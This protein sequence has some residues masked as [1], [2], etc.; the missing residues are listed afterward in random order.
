[1]V[2]VVLIFTEEYAT[3][4]FHR[5]FGSFKSHLSLKFLNL[6]LTIVIKDSLKFLFAKHLV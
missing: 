4:F 3:V 6:D 2:Q 5:H 1:M